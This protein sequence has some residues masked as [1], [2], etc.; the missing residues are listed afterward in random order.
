[1]KEHT[2]GSRLVE[3]V[4]RVE[5]HGGRLAVRVRPGYGLD[6]EGPPSLVA[7]REGEALVLRTPTPA[8]GRAGL[9]LR[10]SSA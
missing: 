1:M 4:R 5:V 6:W 9:G 3:G 8:A 7:E 10:S 2:A